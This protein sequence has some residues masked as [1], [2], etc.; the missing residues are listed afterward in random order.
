MEIFHVNQTSVILDPFVTVKVFKS[1]SFFF[2]FTER[3]KEVLLLWILFVIYDLY[4]FVMLSGL[5]LAA[6]WSLAGK[7]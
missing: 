1:C 5:F 7:G 6:L 4:L 2:I 3:T